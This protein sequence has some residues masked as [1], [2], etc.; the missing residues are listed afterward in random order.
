MQQYYQRLGLSS[1]ADIAEIKKAYRRLALQYHPDRNKSADAEIQFR[2]VAEAYQ[3]LTAYKDGSYL[4]EE[5][6]FQEPTPDYTEQIREEARRKQEEAFRA[7]MQTDDFKFWYYLEVLGQMAMFLILVSFIIG[8]VTVMAILGGGYGFIIGIL[9]VIVC[10]YI[11]YQAVVSTFH[12]LADYVKA[13]QFF[14]NITYVLVFVLIVFNTVVFFKIGMNTFFHSSSFIASFVASLLFFVYWGRTRSLFVV[15]DCLIASIPL[16]ALNVLLLLNY[17][18]SSPEKAYFFRWEPHV[19][20]SRS[21]TRF[22]L[23][24]NSFEHEW[25]VRTLMDFSPMDNALKV[26]ASVLNA[27]SAS[28]RLTYFNGNDKV[29]EMHIAKGFLGFPVLKSYSFIN[30][31]S[32]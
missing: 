6:T 16:L 11:I 17:V 2:L 7:Y 26:S 31:V 29:V 8:L 10:S 22:D 21:T 5:M 1:N 25:H 14:L 18:L 32:D 3:I 15:K 27:A 9:P 20:V 19:E 28:N 23:E 13:V 12:P 30:V 24:N 4:F